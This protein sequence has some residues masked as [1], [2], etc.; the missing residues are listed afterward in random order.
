MRK[1]QDIYPDPFILLERVIGF[2]PTTSC[3]GMKLH[4][5]Q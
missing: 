2:E 3:L 4:I 5:M 1:S